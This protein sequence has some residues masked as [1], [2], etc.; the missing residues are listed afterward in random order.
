MV[1]PQHH[2]PTFPSAVRQLSDLTSGA[3]LACVLS[4]YRPRDLPAAELALG[5]SPSMADGL[6]NIRLAQRLCENVLT[7]VFHV[8]I[9]DVVYM[10]ASVR[11]NVISLLVDMFS[12]LEARPVDTQLLLPGQEDNKVIEVPDPGNGEKKN[13]M[14]FPPLITSYRERERESERKVPKVTKIAQ[15]SGDLTSGEGANAW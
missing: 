10:H 2:Q 12:V 4:L 3:S 11:M 7:N 9:E 8:S 14:R 5:P 15:R 6:L 13:C 1:L